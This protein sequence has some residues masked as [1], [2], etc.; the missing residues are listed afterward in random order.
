MYTEANLVFDQDDY[1]IV[2]IRRDKLRLG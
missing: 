1:N 2:K